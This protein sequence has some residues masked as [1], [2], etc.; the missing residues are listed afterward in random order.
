MHKLGIALLGALVFTLMG[1]A[2][3]QGRRQGPGGPP[4]G[5]DAPPPP[6][7]PQF[8]SQALARDDA[9]KK[10]LEVLD[11]LD[12]NQRRGNMN[13]PKEDGRLLRVLTEAIDAKRV[14]EI[15]TSNG[16]SGLWFC[17]ALQKTGGKLI[18]HEIDEGRAALAR[19]NFKRAGVDDLVTLVMGDAHE[20]VKQITEPFDLLFLDADKEGYLDY[21]AKL[22]PLLKPGGL[23]V[24]HNMNKRQAHLDF[25]KAITEDP[26]LETL[27][28]NT[29]LTGIGVSLKKR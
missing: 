9:E 27:F 15:G 5:E 23:L 19:E 13:V 2:S 29:Y 6:G 20:T 28:L 4:P 21:L 26:N 25:I 16:Y 17:L 7:S 24:A 18:T 3:A 14:V 1:T 10:L 22:M 12:K 11:D 8:D